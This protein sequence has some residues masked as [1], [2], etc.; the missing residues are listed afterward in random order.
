MLV[1]NASV[2]ACG[3]FMVLLPTGGFFVF[4]LPA[5]GSFIVLPL[6]DN[7]SVTAGGPFMLF[8]TLNSN[9][10]VVTH[11]TMIRTHV[12]PD[13]QLYDGNTPITSCLVHIQLNY[14][15]CTESYT[16]PIDL[17][18]NCNTS[19]ITL[20]VCKF[21]SFLFWTACDT[22]KTEVNTKEQVARHNQPNIYIHN[23]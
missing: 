12:V 18:P 1:D 3:H 15:C 23:K 7:A 8:S 19:P 20:F 21:Q 10:D 14:S 2:S 13:R 16:P 17:T 9:S 4:L 5:G 11:W 22:P 6:V